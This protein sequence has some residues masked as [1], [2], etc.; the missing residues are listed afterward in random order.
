VPVIRQQELRGPGEHDLIPWQNMPDELRLEIPPE[1]FLV[2]ITAPPFVDFDQQECVLEDV[3]LR[4]HCKL[5][6]SLFVVRNIQKQKGVLLK[7]L[8]SGDTGWARGENHERLKFV[9]VF[10][11]NS[12]KEESWKR[13]LVE[14]TETFAGIPA[15]TLT[16]EVGK[17][18]QNA[19]RAKSRR[20]SAS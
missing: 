18:L 13:E 5:V 17:K 20:R 7:N 8:K 16:V 10:N 6:N 4:I 12:G 3:P 1:D 2:E 11:L 9:Y 14:N 15:Q 19:I